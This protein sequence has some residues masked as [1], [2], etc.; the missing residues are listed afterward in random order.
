MS[1]NEEYTE[2]DLA[3]SQGY[4]KQEQQNEESQHENSEQDEE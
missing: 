2:P 3:S 4:Q 1:S